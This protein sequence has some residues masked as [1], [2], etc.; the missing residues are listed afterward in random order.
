M[1]SLLFS[2]SGL[3]GIVGPG[4]TPEVVTRYAM[5]FGSFVKGGLVIVGRDTR[6]S[7]DMVKSAVLSGLLST[8]CEVLDIG[9]APTPTV[10]HMVRERKAN[11]GIA[12]TASH[13]PIEWN[14]LKFINRQ[15]LFLDADEAQ[16]FSEFVKKGD[17]TAVGYDQLKKVVAYDLAI[18]E[19]IERIATSPLVEKK[20]RKLKIGVDAVNGAGSRALPMLLSRLGMIV[21]PVHCT[22]D[23]SFPR[24]PEP[25]EEN[26]AALR[27]LISQKRLDLGLAVDPDCDRLALV[28][29]S[30]WVIGEEK[31]VV[32]TAR[33]VLS[34]RRGPIVTNLSTTR[35]I[36]E[37]AR[38]YGVPLYRTKVGE[39]NV[40]TKMREVGAVVGGEGNGGVI[41]PSINATRD[42]LVGAAL[43]V[44]LMSQGQPRLSEIGHA[45]PAYFMLKKKIVV[46]HWQDRF[47]KIMQ[48]VIEHRYLKDATVDKT[49]GFKFTSPDLW[50]HIRASQTEPVVR[51]ICEGTDEQKVQGLVKEVETICAA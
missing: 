23:G 48:C 11:G 20:L 18:E 40:I 45:L 50:L 12:I 31:T 38:E 1:G 41:V 22:P 30:G 21:H 6:L 10:N 34:R 46:E 4:F 5:G 8:G 25:V 2:V 49:D 9:I 51:I 44:S 42:A 19:H 26:L 29:E 37:V 7:G 33:Y 39:A 47:E 13:N 15:G 36:D 24:G 16:E 43:V 3:R 14:A 17:F 27:Q 28:D 32:L 35:L